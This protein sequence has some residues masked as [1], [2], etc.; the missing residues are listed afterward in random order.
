M[1]ERISRSREG[2]GG[3]RGDL[4]SLGVS[5]HRLMQTGRTAGTG[6][7]ALAEIA[8]AEVTLSDRLEALERS[9]ARLEESADAAAHD[10][11]EGLATIAL[12]AEALE[13]R[14]GHELDPAV[15][16]DLD[17]IRAGIERM[18]SLVRATLE[19]G[20]AD[21]HVPV[22]TNVALREAL[23]NLEARM[24]RTDAKVVTEPLPWVVGDA[25]ELMRLFQNL[26]ANAL[27]SQHPERALRIRV[28]ARREGRRWR[29][30]VDDS[31]VGITPELARRAFGSS[32]PKSVPGGG[33]GLAIC[34]RIVDGHGGS[35]R[36]VPRA[37]GGTSV[38][39]DLPACEAPGLAV[40]NR[41]GSLRRSGRPLASRAS[42]PRVAPFSSGRP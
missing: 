14:L 15:V 22:D 10:L 7:D 6:A 32:A 18:S 42:G 9:N 36:A 24:A 23:A 33:L 29:F 25:A 19:S 21:R 5:G 11:A 26:L 34:R 39:F 27:K 28:G 1:H 8:I 31:G 3:K 35:I 20:R 40:V 30:E 12:F 2:A 41:F 13:G 16:H 4:G 17:G 37:E 38:G